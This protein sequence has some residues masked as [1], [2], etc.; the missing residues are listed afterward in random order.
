MKKLTFIVAI[1]IAANVNAQAPQQGTVTGTF[2]ISQPVTKAPAAKSKWTPKK[3]WTPAKKP[4]YY[5]AAGTYKAPYSANRNIVYSYI[6]TV[7]KDA[8]NFFP[9]KGNVGIGTNTPM[10]ALEL[11]RNAGDGDKKNFL[12]SLSN[13][14]SPNGLNEPTIMFNNGDNTANF[15]YWTL[16]ARVSG[17]NAHK[18]PQTFKIGYKAPN[19]P[20]EKEFFSIDSYQGRVKI[21][22][23]NTNVDGYKLYVEEG[24]LTE[25]VKVAVKDSEDWFDNVFEPDY[26]IMPI[27][28]LETYINKN[29]HL[30]EIPT[31]SDVLTNGVDLGKMNGLLLKKVEELTLYMIDLKKELDATKKEIEALKK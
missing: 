15:S 30:P 16:G 23:C 5:S 6:D 22:S 17:D 29:K 19:E 1:L 7:T 13:I 8:E 18:D 20:N 2:T 24:I 11:R 21:G 25:K 10:S 27:K 26:K 4:V 3:K 14:W 28:D 12:L 31:T 9:L